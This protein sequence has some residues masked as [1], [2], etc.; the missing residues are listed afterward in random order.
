M[1]L[2]SKPSSRKNGLLCNRAKA[3]THTAVWTLRGRLQVGLRTDGCVYAADVQPAAIRWLWP[4]RS[5]GSTSL[6]SPAGFASSA[7]GS[8]LA[9]RTDAS[10]RHC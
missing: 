5:A 10:P 7:S 6:D 3:S 8:R 1:F 9:D 2:N 4:L